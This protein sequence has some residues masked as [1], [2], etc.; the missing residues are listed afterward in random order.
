MTKKGLTIALLQGYHRQ[1]PN[2]KASPYGLYKRNKTLYLEQ[3]QSPSGQALSDHLSPT[4]EVW[5]RL[6][7]LAYRICDDIPWAARTWRKT[8]VSGCQSSRPFSSTVS[9]W[10]APNRWRASSACSRGSWRGRSA[11][12]R[13]LPVSC[14]PFGLAH[15]VLGISADQATW[16]LAA[17]KGVMCNAGESSA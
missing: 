12:R 14:R 4:G 11:G 13:A 8:S 1:R 6:F 10:W 7:L 9:G 16:C 15:D 17:S 2:H 5:E 3:P